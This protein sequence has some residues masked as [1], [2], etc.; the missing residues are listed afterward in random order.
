MNEQKLKPCPF[1]GSEA[2]YEHPFDDERVRVYCGKNYCILD[3]ADISFYESF[4]KAAEM[5]NDRAEQPELLTDLFG[6][7][8]PKL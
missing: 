4:E 7:F 6:N 8:D 1:C 3:G 5:W 2:E